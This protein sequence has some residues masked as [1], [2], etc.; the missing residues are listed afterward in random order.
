MAKL[1]QQITLFYS[2]TQETQSEYEL[3]ENNMNG[4]NQILEETNGVQVKL[5]QWKN[6]SS[7]LNKSAQA[8]IDRQISNNYDIYLGVLGTRFGT[9]TEGSGS[10]TEHEYNNAVKAF[11]SDTTKL[12]VWFHFR[13]QIHLDRIDLDQLSKIQE[14]RD[15]IS[16]EGLL[17]WTYNTPEDFVKNLTDQLIMTVTR[18]W[19]EGKWVEVPL[20]SND[21]QGTASYEAK[22][23]EDDLDELFPNNLEPEP[24]E[25]LETLS[26]APQQLSAS[27]QQLMDILNEIRLDIGGINIPQTIPSIPEGNRIATLA[28][29]AIMKANKKIK[30]RL[31]SFSDEINNI[32]DSY[33]LFAN[34]VPAIAIDGDQK[35][36]LSQIKYTTVL[37]ITGLEEMHKDIS[38]TRPI[39]LSAMNLNSKLSYAINQLSQTLNAYDLDIK[40]NIGKLRDW[41]INSIASNK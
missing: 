38:D 18:E 32:I 36:A 6:L 22:L 5:V 41:L 21:P 29:G 10:G 24:L 2:S 30:P 27:R 37:L 14:F 20:T 23:D 12:R 11:K 8:E 9:P 35:S 31:N 34:K 3:L 7:G 13:N 16:S 28:A 4:L 1:L 33:I 26:T 25:L 17:Y 19:R 40:R 15:R 39:L